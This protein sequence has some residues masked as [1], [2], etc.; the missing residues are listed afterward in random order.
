MSKITGWQMHGEAAP[1]RLLAGILPARGI[2]VM[3]GNGARINAALAADLAVAL[4]SSQFGCGLGLPDAE[5]VRAS[6]AGFFGQPVGEPSGVAI[7]TSGSRSA[8]LASVHAAA[9]ARGVT[10]PL[11]IAVASTAGDMA[12]A[13]S[14]GDLGLDR[15]RDGLLRQLRLLIIEANVPTDAIQRAALVGA[16]LAAESTCGCA[17]LLVT[18]GDPAGVVTDG[19]ILEAYGDRLT[20]AKPPAG[21]T[22]WTCSFSTQ[23]IKWAGGGAIAIQPGKAMPFAPKWKAAKPIAAPAP[24]VEP[25]PEIASRHVIF[26]TGRPLEPAERA[27]WADY[28]EVRNEIDALPKPENENESGVH[29]III[30]PNNRDGRNEEAETRAFKLR[31]EARA[32][33]VEHRVLIRISE[34]RVAA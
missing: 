13:I 28:R 2:H 3:T 11:P 8:T 9:L 34:R 22:G 18:Q 1:M 17:V 33:G 20:L 21:V 24:V 16:A 7:V 31:Q 19:V 5:G 6:L 26:I 30:V 10:T 14:G 25:E 12:R 27:P 29:E 4:A 15:V 23:A 32:R